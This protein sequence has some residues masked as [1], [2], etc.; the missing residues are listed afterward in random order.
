M[1]RAEVVGMINRAKSVKIGVRGPE[2]ICYFSISHAQARA[3]ADEIAGLE[4][5]IEFGEAGSG[6]EKV[7]YIESSGL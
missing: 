3:K 5:P 7:L 4:L 1:T 2:H 6:I